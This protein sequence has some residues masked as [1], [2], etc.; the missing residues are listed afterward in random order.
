M[1]L[2]S[3]FVTVVAVVIFLTVVTVVAV[4]TVVT[5]LAG[6][7]VVIVVVVVTVVVVVA[8]VTIV[9][10]TQIWIVTRHQYR[11]SAL[12]P[13]TSFCEETSSDVTKCRLFHQAGLKSIH[14]YR[15]IRVGWKIEQRNSILG[16]FRYGVITGIGREG[17]KVDK[18]LICTLQTET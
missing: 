4:V 3:P 5:V 15:V 2:F 13:E 14:T 10:G 12:V 16:A 6:L 7:T 18:H 9:I 17:L 1:S 8:V 11:M